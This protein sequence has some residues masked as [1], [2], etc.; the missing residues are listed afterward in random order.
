MIKF[1]KIS[2][3]LC[4]F[5]L[6]FAF[7]GCD[8]LNK[9]PSTSANQLI[10]GA[11]KSFYSMR[12]AK[13]EIA[14]NG[15]ALPPSTTPTADPAQDQTQMNRGHFD[16]KLSGLFD[17]KDMTVPDFSLKLDGITQEEGSAE[18]KLN[19]QLRA[20]KDYIY[21]F[22]SGLPDL[23]ENL[24][25]DM[26][27]VYMNQWWR[28]PIPQA[29]WSTINVLPAP[30]EE[31][32]PE[33]LQI[34]ELAQKTDFLK[35]LKYIGTDRVMGVSSYHYS[36]E[37]DKDA[38]KS[39]LV[40]ATELGGQQVVDTQLESLEALMQGTDLNTEIWIGKNDMSLRRVSGNATLMP[41]TGGTVNLNFDI[42]FGYINEDLKIDTPSDVKDFDPN[43]LSG[44]SALD[45]SGA[46]GTDSLLPDTSQTPTE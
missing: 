2:I 20:D 39:F 9:A 29:A 8:L 32:T 46:T 18:Q 19:V 41:A 17:F 15:D 34:R 21:G 4:I 33:Q 40:K 25:T 37:L 31:L 45:L 7:S 5:S 36:G 27:K 23:G 14:L 3:L 1:K 12:S 22:L 43:I 35:N 28:M 16:F 6:V 30:V 11:I 44:A 42:A 26:I 13:Y 10:Q 24:P 38:L